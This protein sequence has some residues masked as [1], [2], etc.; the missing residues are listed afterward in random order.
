MPAE[1]LYKS[2]YLN[3]LN[4]NKSG[5]LMPDYNETFR[6]MKRLRRFTDS[7]QQ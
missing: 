3:K 4:E 2:S 7:S 1:S 6:S 5:S